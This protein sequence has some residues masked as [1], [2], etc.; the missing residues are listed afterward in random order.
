MDRTQI[1]ASGAAMTLGVGLVAGVFHADTTTDAQ[2]THAAAGDH[3][4]AD[5]APPKGPHGGRLL[6]DGDFAAE[7]TIYER[8]VPPQFRVYCS[9][10]GRPIDPTNVSLTIELHRLGGDRDTFR[11]TKE[12]DYL[13]GDGVVEEPHSF[14]VVVTAEHAG[15]THRWTY[16][17]YEGRVALTPEAIESSGL[18]T[19]AAGPETITTGLTLYG[20]VV[21]NENQR[22]RVIPRYPGMVTSLR[23][24][25]GDA[26]EAGEVLAVVQS[27]ESLQPYQ[28]RSPLRGTVIQKHT[29]VGEFTSDGTVMYVVADLSVVWIDLHVHHRDFPRLALGQPVVIRA[30]DGGGSATASLSY[31]SPLGDAETQTM[32]ARVELPNPSGRW[33]PGWFVTGE[34]IVEEVTVPLAVK[35]SALQT[36]R[37]WDVVFVNVDHVFEV[38]PL[39]LGRRDEDWVEV[40]AGLSVGQ[41]YVTENSF[42]IKADIGKSGATHDH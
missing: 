9:A 28:V 18:G 12:Q 40:L 16:P 5:A 8:G 26:V 1:L 34:V 32:L 39:E 11:F 10:A 7:V 19:A 42:I 3:A 33:R 35:S 23:K 37:D 14:D 25:L 15:Q 21:P 13:R 38:R 2:T 6:T 24:Q 41:R 4:A 17:S 20:R 30:P 29:T 22:A 36:F 27:N 31:L